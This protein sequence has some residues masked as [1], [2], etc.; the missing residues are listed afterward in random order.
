MLTSTERHWLKQLVIRKTR[1]AVTFL[2]YAAC[3]R[4]LARKSCIHLNNL[5]QTTRMKKG[6]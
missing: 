4:W 3:T 1:R 6:S 5:F 2:A